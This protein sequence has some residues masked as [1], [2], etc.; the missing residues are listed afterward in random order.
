MLIPY[1]LVIKWISVIRAVRSE[2]AFTWPTQDVRGAQYNK[3]DVRLK[4]SF[5]VKGLK[6][7]TLDGASK[8]VRLN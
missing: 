3:D 6:W 4:E 1:D 8:R 2:Q 7:T 5:R